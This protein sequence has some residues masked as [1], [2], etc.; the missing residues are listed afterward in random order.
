MVTS[1]ILQTT[2]ECVQQASENTADT[3]SVSS[4]VDRLIDAGWSV[5][6][7]GEVGARA[8]SVMAVLHL[9]G[10]SDD[11]SQLPRQPR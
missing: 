10:W 1:R 11:D 5:E 3:D 7:A 9:P 2:T 8:L 4:F 6:D